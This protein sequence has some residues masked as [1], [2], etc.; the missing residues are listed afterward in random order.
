MNNI[1]VLKVP[2]ELISKGSDPE[3]YPEASFELDLLKQQLDF[4]LHHGK[5]SFILPSELW[6][7][8]NTP[9]YDIKIY[10]DPINYEIKPSDVNDK[11]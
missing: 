8:T 3:E 11:R 10:G 6:E 9:M 1:I 2:F 4:V 5:T 7:G